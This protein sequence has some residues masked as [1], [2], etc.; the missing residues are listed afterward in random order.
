MASR[1][2]TAEPDVEHT[3]PPER[4]SADQRKAALFD[5]AKALVDEAGPGRVTI[6]AVAD[7]AGVTR[8]LVYKHFGNKDDLL[9]ALYRREAERL[10]RKIAAD[11]AATP[12][13]FEPKLRA[14]IGATLDAVEEHAP[15]FTPLREA[16]AGR[17][18]RQD[19]RRRDRR[20]VDYF[21]RQA[22]TDFDVDL[23]TARS[24]IAVLF[25]GIRSLL[26]QMRSR[27]GA[28]QREFLLDTYVETALGALDR[29]A[30][31]GP[32]AAPRS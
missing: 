12:D 1:P 18:T 8:A 19:Q 6:G 5:A 15:F 25:S 28:A 29:L 17:S 20:T 13:G 7:R 14:F 16:G 3:G 27:P 9:Q 22:A 2:S 30:R 4:L 31:R 24:V 11:V 21:A 26:S 32:P 23:R 10:D